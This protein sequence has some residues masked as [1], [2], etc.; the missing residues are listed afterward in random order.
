MRNP[1]YELPKNYRKNSKERELKQRRRVR[2]R[3]KNIEGEKNVR[4]REY[5]FT[6]ITSQF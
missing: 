5:L 4:S 3:E 2:K 1:K 6:F